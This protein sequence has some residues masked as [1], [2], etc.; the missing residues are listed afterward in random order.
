M[1]SQPPIINP[2]VPFLGYIFGGLSRGRMVIIQGQVRPKAQSISQYPSVPPSIS[3]YPPVPPP[4]SH[5]PGLAGCHGEGQRFTVALRC[6]GGDVAL[7]LNARLGWGVT[8]GCNAQLGGL[9]GHEELCTP[10]P[11][12]LSPG[13]A[14][15]IL[16]NAQERGYQ[17]AVNGQ[18]ALEFRHRLPLNSVQALDVTGDV[19]L[20]CVTFTGPPGGAGGDI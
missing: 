2:S 20:T 9:W 7:R 12:G 1:D 6:M 3:Q 14:L 16:I 13:G 4:S 11:R 5:T 8:L 19:T 15:E 18:H 17:V 10:P